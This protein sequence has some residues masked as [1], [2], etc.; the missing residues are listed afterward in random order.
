MKKKLILFISIVLLSFL[1]TACSTQKTN[2]IKKPFLY[3]ISKDGKVSYL[4]GT[5]HRGVD[6]RE[7][8]GS[9]WKY[10]DNADALA[11]ESDEK[12][13]RDLQDA[14]AE[15]L[16]RKNDQP[17][18][19]NV[20]NKDDFLTVKETLKNNEIVSKNL[21][22][23]SLEG[24]YFLLRKNKLLTNQSTLSNPEQEISRSKSQLDSQLRSKARAQGKEIIALDSIES[25]VSFFIGLEGKP[26]KEAIQNILGSNIESN[27]KTKSS[28]SNEVEVEVV[29]AYRESNE[30]NINMLFSDLPSWVLKTRNEQWTQKMIS[31]M[32]KFNS[33][34]FAVGVGHIIVDAPYS[35]IRILEMNG[36]K[37]RRMKGA[38]FK[39]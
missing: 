11:T 31:L 3:E 17:K 19:S 24:I 38:D 5:I 7:F 32:E 36:Y 6:S 35:L 33:V 2:E 4:F 16:I 37:I 34:F 21:D 12:M 8:H 9:M 39:I 1:F 13:P 14:F 10:F 30:E 27:A 29:K 23:F 22:N 20:L 26:A 25:T 18:L 28:T 15:R